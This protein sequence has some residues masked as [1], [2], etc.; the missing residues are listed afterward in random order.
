M[1]KSGATK[2]NSQESKAFS[3]V[4]RLATQLHK[5]I[6]SQF[7]NT[8]LSVNTF[9]CHHSIPVIE[10]R[11]SIGF[12]TFYRILP[13]IF[14]NAKCDKKNKQT[15]NSTYL[16]VFINRSKSNRNIPMKKFLC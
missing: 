12:Y 11:F 1:F 4:T 3:E 8:Q 9:A 5:I 15:R 13:E 7:G 2:D 10:A 16:T 14:Q 6:L